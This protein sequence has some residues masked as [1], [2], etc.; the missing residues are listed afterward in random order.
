MRTYLSLLILSMFYSVMGQGVMTPKTIQQYEEIC[1]TPPPTEEQINERIAAA[2]SNL[3]L[4]STTTYLPIRAFIV[5]RSDGTGGLSKQNLNIGLS[6]L[7][8]HYADA[9]VVFYYC[10]VTY[11]M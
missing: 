8:Y 5:R 6:Y 1:A 9:S 3:S 10:D 4:L 2:N 7:N 11:M